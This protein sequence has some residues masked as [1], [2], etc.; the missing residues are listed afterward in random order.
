MLE[1]PGGRVCD[2]R[3]P[4]PEVGSLHVDHDHETGA[5]RGLLCVRCNNGLGRL[6]ESVETLLAAIA[7]LD[8]FDARDRRDGS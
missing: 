6:D 2:L 3:R 8:E 7:Y 5:V 1:G 4:P